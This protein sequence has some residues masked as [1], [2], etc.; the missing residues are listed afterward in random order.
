MTDTPLRVSSVLIVDD[1]PS[2]DR[3][4][5]RV[6]GRFHHVSCEAS[7]EK[8]LARISAGERFDAIVCDLHMPG[9]TG[10]ALHAELLRIAH[11]Q[12]ARMIFMTGNA[13]TR[14]VR[15]F[16]DGVTN[17]HLEKPFDLGVLEYMVNELVC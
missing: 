9:M 13:D 6:L 17:R 11:D 7:A 3:V 15:G 12:A 2:M 10:M 16:L 4:M 8:A 14:D 5:T 1:E